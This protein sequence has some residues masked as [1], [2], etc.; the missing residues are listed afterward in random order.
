[1]IP[2]HFP[3]LNNVNLFNIYNGKFLYCAYNVTVLQHNTQTVLL[4]WKLHSSESNTRIAIQYMAKVVFRCDSTTASPDL[5][6]S[7]VQRSFFFSA[8]CKTGSGDVCHVEVTQSSQSEV[9]YKC[10][11]KKKKLKTKLKKGEKYWLNSWMNLKYFR[12][13]FI[14]FFYL[15]FKII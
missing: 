12:I 8:W 14:E 15:N 3:L 9:R 1:M 4:F 6:I 11:C 7:G 2:S 10:L 5:R 13:E